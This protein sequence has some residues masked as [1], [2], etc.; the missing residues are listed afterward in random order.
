MS[1]LFFSDIEDSDDYDL[2]PCG[3]WSG[4]S[5]VCEDA[6]IGEGRSYCEYCGADGDA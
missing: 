3:E 6:E 5:W 2:Q 4:H 1:T